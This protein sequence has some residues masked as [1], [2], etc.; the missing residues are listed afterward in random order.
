MNIKSKKMKILHLVCFPLF[1]SGSGT[2]V[3]K[4][5]EKTAKEFPEDEVAILSVDKKSTFQGVKIFPLKLP[6]N[7]AFTGHPDWK[8]YKLYSELNQREINTLYESFRR[9][10]IRVVD[11]FKP[12]IIHVHHASIFS[13]IAHYI[14]A[15]YG[16]NYVVSVHGT[17]VLC[18]DQDK[19]WIPLVRPGLE[20]AF[21]V[22]P[23]SSDTKKW[24]LRVFG[25]SYKNKTRVRPGGVDIE[26]FPKSGTTE[27]VDKMYNLDNKDVVIF[28]GK[29]TKVKGVE[30]LLKAAPKIDAKI[31]IIGGGEDKKRLEQLAKKL[32]LKNVVFT[33]YKG[34]DS[35]EEFRQFYRRASVFVFP[36]VW[37]EPL[38]LVALEAMS[39]STPVVASDK[40]GISLAVKNGYNGFLIPS[41]SPEAISKKVNILLHDKK[42]QK[43][44]SQNARATVESKFSWRLISRK[45]HEWYVAAH[46][47][48]E[49][50]KKNK[51]L[52]VDKRQIEEERK[53]VKKKGL[54]Y[55]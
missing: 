33:G 39:S 51:S 45:F 13:S 40:G 12:D 3:R 41:K 17:G 7:V 16:I 52:L 29:L 22:I 42:L 37:D 31:F 38:G 10:T 43:K 44:F 15:V 4:L 24:M 25:E 19:R 28:A 30:Y 9:Q 20:S 26:A 46:E 49:E 27:I 48:S 34:K 18:A 55:I 6:F 8:K 2:F 50:Y 35:I 14:K 36:S 11:M 23:V 54:D 21:Y 47:R 1:G 32:N 53:D 5:A